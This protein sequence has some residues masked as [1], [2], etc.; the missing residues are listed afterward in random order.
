MSDTFWLALIAGLPATI[1]ALAGLV[2]SWKGRQE[3]AK[4]Q[5]L[6]HRE[7]TAAIAESAAAV[8]ENKEAVKKLDDHLN[9]NLD[10]I[11]A[12]AVKN[13]LTQERLTVLKR[14]TAEAKAP[15]AAPCAFL[16]TDPVC[17]K[18]GKCKNY[19]PPEY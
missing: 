1:T 18:A 11:V 2:T 5:E 8:Q 14:E 13:A 9:G 6:M 4:K 3:L 16:C 10:R 17:V 7:N 12:E 19:S 15:A